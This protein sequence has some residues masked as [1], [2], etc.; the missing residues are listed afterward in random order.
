[1]SSAT[2]SPPAMPLNGAT[3]SP[4]VAPAE[5]RVVYWAADWE[6]YEGLLAAIGERQIRI[7]YHRGSLELMAPS[8][9]HEWWSRRLDKALTG[10]GM[11]LGVDF[12]GAGSTTF[13]RRDIDGGLEPDQGYYTANAHRMLG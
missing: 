8:W 4:Y 1:M 7:T 11:A 10:V 12:I 2:V 6:M 9:N 5:Q 3:Q 13:R